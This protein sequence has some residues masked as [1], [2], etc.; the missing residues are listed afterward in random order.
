MRPIKA[1]TVTYADG[2]TET[3]TGD[4]SVDYQAS[5]VEVHRSYKPDGTEATA[6]E[7]YPWVKAH[8]R[9]PAAKPS[10]SDGTMGS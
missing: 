10:L 9:V 6:R 2:T 1:M 8:L 5:D 7:A 3:W 4:G